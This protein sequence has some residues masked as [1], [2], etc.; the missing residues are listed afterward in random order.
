MYSFL[1]KPLKYIYFC[2][3]NWQNGKMRV[4]FFLLPRFF[5]SENVILIGF[6][7]QINKLI[8]NISCRFRIGQMFRKQWSMIQFEMKKLQMVWLFVWTINQM[9]WCLHTHSFNWAKWL[10]DVC[11]FLFYLKIERKKKK[12]ISQKN[13]FLW[14]NSKWLLFILDWK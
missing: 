5:V 8:W 2:K 11:C 9:K 13:Q 4:K 6:H 12:L 14:F 7:S 1:R 3:C 10:R